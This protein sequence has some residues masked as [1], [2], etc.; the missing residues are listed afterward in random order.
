M[1]RTARVS[2]EAVPSE[3]AVPGLA[4]DRLPA[5]VWGR[6]PGGSPRE[7]VSRLASGGPGVHARRGSLHGLV[8]HVTA[9]KAWSVG[10]HCWDTQTWCRAWARCLN[11][12]L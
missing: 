5:T 10:G 4:G 9:M 2:S 1:S 11:C 12:R 8:S 3:P 6:G 7:R